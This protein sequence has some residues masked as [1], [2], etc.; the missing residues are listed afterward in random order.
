VSRDPYEILSQARLLAGEE[1]RQFLD[2]ACRSD[3]GLREDIEYLLRLERPTAAVPERL[4][5]Y[6]L[7]REIARGGMG[8][9]YEALDE[10][11]DRR[12]AV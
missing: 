5:R 2:R 7:L 12:V 8:V 6:R 4:G 10:R 9:V 3:P 11:L 1:L